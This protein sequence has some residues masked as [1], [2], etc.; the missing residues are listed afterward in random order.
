MPHLDHL[1]SCLNFVIMKIIQ[2]KTLNE[3]EKNFNVTST[4]IKKILF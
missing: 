2:N 4:G 1:F 3:F